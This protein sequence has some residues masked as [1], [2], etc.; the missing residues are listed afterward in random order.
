MKH[1]ANILWHF[2]YLG[3]LDAIFCFLIGGLLVLT[4][5][6]API[7]LGL[8][9]LGKLYLAPFGHQM[10]EAKNLPNRKKPHLMWRVFS[11]IIKILYLPLGLFLTL[12]IVFQMIGCVITVIGF[13][14]AVVLFKSLGT[15]WN[16]VGKVR[17]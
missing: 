17:V 4:G 7:G 5:I 14:V 3:F 1:I 12:I 8:I 13:P 15:I 6:G 16:P 11:F 10:V 2:P 9:E